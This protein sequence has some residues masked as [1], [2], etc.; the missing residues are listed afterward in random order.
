MITVY[1]NV[2][3]KRVAI[4]VLS[5]LVQYLME[6]SIFIPIITVVLIELYTEFFKQVF[7][8]ELLNTKQGHMDKIFGLCV[9]M[10]CLP[11]KASFLILKSFKVWPFISILSD[12]G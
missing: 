2:Y 6:V 4:I 5:R 9:Y 11:S 8:I 3:E 10:C 1:V 12:Y 7:K